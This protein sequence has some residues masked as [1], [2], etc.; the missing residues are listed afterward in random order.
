[1]RFGFFSVQDFHPEL[2]VTPRE[3][4][5]DVLARIRAAEALGCDSFWLAEHHFHTYGLNPAPPVLLAAAARETSRIRLG[6][7]IAVLPFHH[8]VHLAEHYAMLDVISDGRLDFGVGSG[9]LEHEFAGFNIPT[10]EKSARFEEA[11]EVILQAWSGAA[12]THSGPYFNLGELHLQVTPIQKPHPPVFVGILRAESAYRVGRQGRQI[13]GVPYTAVEH[14]SDMAHVIAEFRRGYA[15]AGCDPAKARIPMALHAFVAETEAEAEKLARESLDRYVATRLYA[16][17]SLMWTELRDR[18]LVAVGTPERV[19][20][21]ISILEHAGATDL[22][23]L[24][25]FGGLDHEVVLGSMELF[26]REV[27]PQFH[28][29]AVAG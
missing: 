4:F 14:L 2:G 7:A 26:A 25:D 8:P 23:C 9:Y 18:Q 10:E 11:L 12:F 29:V 28:T 6:S 13:M 19:S 1:V 15:E 20:E 16:R 22:L 3:Y 21:T 27:A 17:R 24:M 5:E